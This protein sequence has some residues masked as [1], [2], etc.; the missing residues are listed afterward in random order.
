MSKLFNG[1]EFIRK[2][3]RIVVKMGICIWTAR[4]STDE[5]WLSLTLETQLKIL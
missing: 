5:F 1:V 2:G 4:L 3:L